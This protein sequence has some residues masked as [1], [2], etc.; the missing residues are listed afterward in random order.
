V[1]NSILWANGP[2]E[3]AKAGTGP[4]ITSS[5]V[6]GGYAGEGN[7]DVDPLLWLNADARPRPGSGCIDAG[8]L[9]PAGG[10]PAQDAEGNPRTL[11]GNNDGNSLTDMGAYEFVPGGPA[12]SALPIV[13]QFAG[14]WAAQ[15]RRSNPSRPATP[16]SAH[17]HC[18][19]L[20][21]VRGWR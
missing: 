19:S 17:S 15:I 21:H 14:P 3:V 11:D 20:G 2:E 12:L 8:T 9:T 6:L 5:D 18:R 1:C 7:L 10:L 4:T 16:G 13:L